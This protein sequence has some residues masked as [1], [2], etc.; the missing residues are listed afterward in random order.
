MAD[1]YKKIGDFTAVSVLNDSDVFIVSRNGTTYNVP[2]SVLKSLTLNGSAEI[3]NVGGTNYW[4]VYDK[5]RKQMVQSVPAQLK[6]DP[7]PTI[8]NISIRQSDYHL[9]VSMSDGTSYDAGYCRGQSGAGTG[10]MQASDYDPN[11]VVLAS[12]GIVAYINSLNGDEVL[13]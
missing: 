7:A 13:Y 2:G 12:G 6:G 4:F 5:D 3:R 9:I 8:T 1:Q 11:N 10:D